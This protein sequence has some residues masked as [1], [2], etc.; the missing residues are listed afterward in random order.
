MFLTNFATAAQCVSIYL[1]FYFIETPRWRT[2]H[3]FS[4]AH[5]PHVRTRFICD[6]YAIL[7]TIL[8]NGFRN[9]T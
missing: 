2:R 3:T 9:E 5:A 6:L 8:Q 4:Y 1:S 7:M